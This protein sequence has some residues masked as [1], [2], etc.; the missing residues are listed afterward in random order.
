MG[1]NI[2]ILKGSQCNQSFLREMKKK[3]KLNKFYQ[4]QLLGPIEVLLITIIVQ[5]YGAQGAALKW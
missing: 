5:H 2:F 3:K 1:D 4:Q